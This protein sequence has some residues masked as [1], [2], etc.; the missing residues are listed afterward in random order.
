MSKIIWWKSSCCQKNPKEKAP[1]AKSNPVEKAAAVGEEGSV[2]VLVAGED[3][4][5]IVA[6]TPVEPGLARP[7]RK[8]AK[9]NLATDLAS[10]V[11]ETAGS[12]GE[13][14]V[15]VMQTDQVP[16]SKNNKRKANPVD[17]T[18][19]EDAEPTTKKAKKKY[20]GEGW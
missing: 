9:Y 14:S 5:V 17:A 11:D 7:R 1:A 15:V 3:A 13:V 10:K 19:I 12:S 18:V 8:A 4:P 20:K 6:A 2:V 16:K